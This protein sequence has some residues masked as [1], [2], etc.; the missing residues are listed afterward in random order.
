MT[1]TSIRQ[2]SL[3]Q[4]RSFSCI[5]YALLLMAA[6]G[7][8]QSSGPGGAGTAAPAAP[9]AQAPAGF[10]LP[11][12]L[13]LVNAGGADRATS[14]TGPVLTHGG[15]GW[16]GA[17]A[18]RNVTPGPGDALILLPHWLGEN[19]SPE[20]LAIALYRFNVDGFTGMP[21][22]QL[23]WSSVGQGG[24]CYLAAADFSLNRWKYY[25]GAAQGTVDLGPAL[26]STLKHSASGDVLLAIICIG[27][28]EWTLERL[29]LGLDAEPLLAGVDFSDPPCVGRAV[30]LFPKYSGISPVDWEWNFGGLPGAPGVMH[31]ATAHLHYLS[32]AGTFAAE[33]IA[34]DTNGERHSLSYNIDIMPAAQEA[35]VVEGVWP[36][37]G[38]SG[39]QTQF[40]AV[41]GRG[42]LP[43]QWAWNFGGGATPNTVNGRLA[44]VVLGAAGTYNASVTVTSAGA[45]AT[46]HQFELYVADTGGILP[47]RIFGVK[48]G[49]LTRGANVFATAMNSGG[50]PASA[51]WSCPGLSLSSEIAERPQISVPAPG[52][53][54]ASVTFTNS[55]GSD[56][57]FFKLIVAAQ[58]PSALSVAALPVLWTELP[59][60]VQWNSPPSGS[61]ADLFDLGA[62]IEASNNQLTCTLPGI[63]RC[64]RHV[65]FGDLHSTV[66]FD[67]M[68]QELLAPEISIVYLGSGGVGPASAA[69]EAT[70]GMP[71]YASPVN[72]GGPVLDWDWQF[73]ANCTPSSSTLANPDLTF[74]ATGSQACSVTTTN[75]RGTHT[76]HFT[77]YVSPPPPPHITGVNYL[78]GYSGQSLSLAAHGNTYLVSA[79]E[80]DFGGACT[81]GISA[82]ERPFAELLAPGSYQCSVK[83]SNS[84]GASTYNFTF[85]VLPPPAPQIHSISPTIVE[86]GEL[87]DFVPSW[88]GGAPDTWLWSFGGACDPATSADETPQVEAL[89]P[90]SYNCS[91]SASN[92]S[93]SHQFNFLLTI[94]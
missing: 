68:V 19:R 3:I 80:W 64:A 7:C 50:E 93:G 35:V 69:L 48:T 92:S 59:Q 26:G 70:E 25:S 54:P 15:N 77:V 65:R 91:V 61:T 66:W 94:E 9:L 74:T 60:L 51:L 31:G 30:T 4:Q 79:W 38:H 11:S 6:A 63:Y 33:L 23:D 22:V 57:H 56:T 62:A 13:S 86:Q 10:S 72:L 29:R 67:I 24:D 1:R 12:P 81:P 14:A 83:A 2:M 88:S 53:Y 20:G 44:N 46:V 42:A 41:H 27:A 84:G 58:E 39:E 82:E 52:L 17:L 18:P 36:G 49:V 43:A 32:T 73:G 40:H 85:T 89:A 90:G 34:I 71:Y 76:F 75:S 8:G 28:A 78:Q 37:A 47:P 45:V 21:R 55:A 16:D 87:V 5:L